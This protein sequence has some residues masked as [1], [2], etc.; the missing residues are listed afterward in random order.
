MSEVTSVKETLKVS[1]HVGGGS[2]DDVG[3][4]RREDDVA[5]PPNAAVAAAAA[6]KES[7]HV[8]GGSGDDDV[9]EDDVAFPPNAAAAAAAAAA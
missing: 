2:G 4:G 1:G 7:G 3:D 8:G 9:G 6:L 5:F